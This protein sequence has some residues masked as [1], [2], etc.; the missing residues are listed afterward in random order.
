MAKF[1]F[2]INPKTAKQTGVTI[3]EIL[4]Y[5]ADRVIHGEARISLRFYFGKLRECWIEIER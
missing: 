1:E 3:L 5:G 4:L 2:V